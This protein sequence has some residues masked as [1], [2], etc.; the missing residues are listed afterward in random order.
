[1][2]EEYREAITNW[3]KAQERQQDGTQ[4]AV[5]QACLDSA[6]QILRRKEEQERR[7]RQ[8]L[9]IRR[10]AALI[11]LSLL[12]VG[13]GYLLHRPAAPLDPVLAISRALQRPDI[14]IKR[15]GE[16]L[17]LQGIVASPGEKQ[18]IIAAARYAANR[19]VDGSGL[20]VR[21]PQTRSAVSHGK[22]GNSE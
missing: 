12:S 17:T 3:Q 9:Q 22:P 7:T 2:K 18:I 21:A 13:S 6:R 10:T 19:P 14:N 1:Q 11:G 8:S 16:R 4:A 20:K 15:V 5:L